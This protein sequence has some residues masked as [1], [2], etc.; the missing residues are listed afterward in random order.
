VLT[1]K[2]KQQEAAAATASVSADTSLAELR[3]QLET[4][5]AEA[6]RANVEAS[7]TGKQY[8]QLLQRLQREA[9]A[10]EQAGCVRVPSRAA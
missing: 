7:S 9:D 3:M 1:D 6:R 10:S 5:R 4:E 2:A 8:A